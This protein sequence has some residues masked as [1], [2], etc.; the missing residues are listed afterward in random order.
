MCQ[1]VVNHSYVGLSL[2]GNNDSVVF[3]HTDLA[4]SCLDKGVAESVLK[5]TKMVVLLMDLTLFF[6]FLSSCEIPLIVL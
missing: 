4:G 1:S 6:I 2:V 3:C 5:S